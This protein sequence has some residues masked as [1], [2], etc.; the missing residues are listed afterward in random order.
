MD[1]LDQRARRQLGLATTDQ[2][3]ELGWTD[4]DIEW[5]VEA[6]RIFRVRKGVI[7]VAGAPVTR[8]QTW[9][10]A[11]LAAPDRTVLGLDTGAAHWAL[12]GFQPD[13]LSAI[14]LLRRG[15]QPL[16][17]VGIRGHRTLWLP[18]R[19]ITVFGSIP[20][21]TPERTLVDVCGHL[22]YQML[23][24]SVA[25][26][27]RRRLIRLPRLAR[28]FEEVPTSGRRASKPMKELLS[29]LG[30]D[31]NPGGS[32]EELDVMR[33]LRR[34]GVPL[35]V[36]QHRVVIGGRSFFLDYAYPPAMEAM[37]WDSY[38]FHGLDSAGF[39]REKW[40]TRQL[41][42]VGWKIWPLTSDTSESEIIEIA[43]R[44]S[45]ASVRDHPA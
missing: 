10:A 4:R 25:D 18:D 21:T 6:G 33:I 19:D 20:V 39:H 12:R 23:R 5:A 44:A 9:L 16:R 2:L 32:T 40:R 28:C 14:D 15:S 34:A 13:S 35:P 3:A 36:Q 17:G 30:A 11:V 8:Q 31:F 7:R 42:A 43:T 41:Q 37:E 45:L 22:P 1:S 24:S 38:E 29:E 26:A 27:A